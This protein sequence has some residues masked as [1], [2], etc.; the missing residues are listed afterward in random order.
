MNNP[1]EG[2]QPLSKESVADVFKRTPDLQQRRKCV[3]AL[4]ALQNPEVAE[5][6]PLYDILLQ[7]TFAEL[8]FE[9]GE[10]ESARES[11]KI[12]H[13]KIRGSLPAYGE[14]PEELKGPYY[15][16]S[17]LDMQIKSLPLPPI[18]PKS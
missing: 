9:A 4:L 12:G 15:R 13:E 5:G 3:Q 14:I 10:I 2:P 8:Y 1:I 18:K 16:L 6:S 17:E 11:M 7:T